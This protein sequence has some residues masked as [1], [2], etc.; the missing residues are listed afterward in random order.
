MTDQSSPPI[1]PPRPKTKQT[2]PRRVR[3]ASLELQIKRAD[4]KA[5]K[6]K[7]KLLGNHAKKAVKTLEKG[8][9]AF[10]EPQVIEKATQTI[11]EFIASQIVIFQPNE[12]PQT[13][14]LAA[15]ER[16]VLFG[17]AAGGG[18]SFAILADA[19]RDCGNGNHRAIIFRRTNDELRELIG[20]SKQLY[21]KAFPGA[22]FSEKSSQWVFPSGATIWFTYLERDD[23]VQRY[24]GQAFNYIAFDELT[25]YPTPHAW[26]YM[27]S[28]LRTTDKKLSL[29]MRATTNP[30]HAGMYWVKKMF[31]DPAPWGQPFWAQDEDGKVLA[32]PPNHIKAGQPLFKRRFIPSK[33]SDNPYLYEDGQYEANL[34]SL[35]EVQ[36]RQLLEGSWDLVEGA[37]FSEFNRAIHVIKQSDLPANW[38]NW[39]CFRAADYGYSS[40]AGCVWLAI[41]PDNQLVV[42]RELYLTKHNSVQFAEK[43]MQAEA[44]DNIQYGVLDSSCFHRRGDIGPPI[45]EQMAQA[46]V[47]WRPSDRSKG[48]RIAGKNEL[49]RRLSVNESGRPGLV[50]TDNCVNLIA[51]LPLLPLDKSNPEDVDTDSVDHLYDALRYGLMSR[52]LPHTPLIG[53]HKRWAPADTAFGY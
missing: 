32:Y 35:P 37:A 23:D 25:Q 44:G 46:G 16:E 11:Q 50:I 18:K 47:R 45:S 22:R 26:N 10:V 49:H 40:W 36:R 17:G 28:R 19:L 9:T 51:Q 27:R 21:L 24:Q 31:V 29:Y 33:L 8:E 2:K 4:R 52:P 15:S 14:F 43:V 12:G 48:S 20:K 34:L 7:D 30:G 39:K 3:E 42:Y 38:K 5:Q 53:F 6:L 13:Q 41:A 1:L